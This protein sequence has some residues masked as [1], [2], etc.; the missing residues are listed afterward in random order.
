[1]IT[2]YFNDACSKCRI[3]LGIMN[4][5]GLE[6]TTVEYLKNP[7]TEETLDSLL[8]QLKMEPEQ[9]V[10]KGED[11][12]EALESQGALPKTRKGWIQLMVKH[13]ILIERPI[14]SDGQTAV[15]GRPPEKIV[16]WLKSRS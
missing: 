2:L 15:V 10:R 5:S 16:E 8:K 1:M 3:S 14:V 6:F 11:E 7:P 9:L 12:Y 13:P 4:D